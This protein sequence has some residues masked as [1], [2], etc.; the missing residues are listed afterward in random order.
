MATLSKILTQQFTP[1]LDGG[2][3]DLVFWENDQTITYSYTIKGN[4]NALLASCD[5][6]QV[7]DSPVDQ[8]AWAIYRQALRDITAQAGFPE[9]VIWP[10]KP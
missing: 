6:T 2:G 10:I 1:G 8:S 7:A 4:R 9:N 3:D 5:W